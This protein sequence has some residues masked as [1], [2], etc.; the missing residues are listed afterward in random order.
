MYRGPSFFF[1]LLYNVTNGYIMSALCI[2]LI[3]YVHTFASYLVTHDTSTF[4]IL[5]IFHYMWLLFYNWK[6][7]SIVRK[8]Q[9]LLLLETNNSVLLLNAD[10]EISNSSAFYLMFLPQLPIHAL[11]GGTITNSTVTSLNQLPISP[12]SPAMMPVAKMEAFY[13]L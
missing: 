4:Y 9:S 2:L 10:Y 6:S 5:I 13:S 11:M 1:K 7:V 8:A 12:G 3:L